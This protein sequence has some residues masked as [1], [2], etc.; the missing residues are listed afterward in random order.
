MS[1]RFLVSIRDVVS[2][3]QSTY[4]HAKPKFGPREVADEFVLFSSSLGGIAFMRR[5]SEQL[6][7]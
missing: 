6:W 7:E 4:E 3:L 1:G 5:I 2:H